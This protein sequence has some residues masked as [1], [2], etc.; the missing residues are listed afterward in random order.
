M[1]KGIFRSGFRHLVKNRTASI[2]NISGMAISVAICLLILVWTKREVSYDNFHP[3]VTNKY[4][5]W[6]TFKS[7]SETF[8]QA[9][10]G[11]AL[12]AQ[13][14]KHV[15]SIIGSCRIFYGDFKFSYEKDTYFEHR[16]IQADSNFFNFFGFKLIRG[17]ADQV[18]KTPNEVVMTEQTAIKYFGSVDSAMGKTVMMLNTA[19][20]VSGVSANPPINSHIRFDI[21]IPYAW[22]HGYALTTYK[23]DIDNMWVGGWPH[24]YVELARGSN[25]EQTSKMVNDVVAQFSKKEWEDNKMSYQYILQPIQDIHLKSNLRYDTAN[26]NIL[27]VKVFLAIGIFILLLACINYINLTT[28]TA[29]QR[30]K[31]ISLRKVVGASRKQL[32]RQFFS[33]TLAVTIVAVVIGVSVLELSLP[34][35]SEW[36]DQPYHFELNFQTIGMLAVF[37]ILVTFLSGFYPSIVL[38]SFQ[39]AA[40]LKGRFAHSSSGQFARKALVIAQFTISTVLVI[41]IIT[42]NQQMRYIRHASLGYNSEAVL[43]VNFNGE[44]D[45]VKKY[46][47][48]QQQ[49]LS[50]PYITSVSRHSSPLVGGFGNGWITTEDLNGKEVTTSIYR[51]D[52]DADF[53]TT[54]DLELASG[55]FFSKD[56]DS[57]QSV[58]V[59]EAAVRV[60]GWQKP[61]NAIGKPFGKGKDARYVIGVIKDFHF[62]N[63]HK[64]VEPVLIGF[65]RGGYCISLKIEEGQIKQAI[66]HLERV[67]TQVVPDIPL[68]YEFI[69]DTLETQYT[70]ED[71]IE[72][73]FYLLSGLSLTIA[74]MG[75]FG[76]STFMLQQRTREVGIR[77]VLGAQ[78]TGIVILLTGDFS[79]LVLISVL[80]ASP[81]GWFIMRGW[82]DTF[83][84]H[85]ELRW[86]IFAF[87]LII[88]LVIALC[89][90]SFHSIKTAL[91]N[92]VNSLRSE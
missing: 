31:E 17:T 49:L 45:V 62:E 19:M 10:S 5:V 8:S 82:L 60:L 13:L 35:F 6:N 61:E 56:M 36:M 83:A 68:Q 28:A 54:Y 29:I 66:S 86:W 65:E 89:T 20:T 11:V 79:K 1:Q 80:I 59:N 7:E 32:I 24:T 9:P 42:V 27:T 72:T 71:K 53:K 39:P 58:L 84:Y 38:S 48:I 21:V 16:A 75:L 87:G 3:N 30:A 67:W 34:L 57:T 22:L 78:V 73:V 37:A 46:T 14:P 63:L 41:C 52:V 88:P 33:E 43:T 40:A 81:I 69:D 91:S 74:C 26:G 92:P 47:A 2:L 85:T 18:L 44:E 64:R 50:V 55:R 51:L 4:R 70:N 12:G 90:V 23:E 76:L 25:V 15:P 77:K